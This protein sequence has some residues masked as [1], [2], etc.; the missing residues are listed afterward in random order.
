MTI[1]DSELDLSGHDGHLDESQQEALDEFKKQVEEQF[2][3][4]DSH[5]KWYDDTTLL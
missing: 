5:V 3:G 1:P 4:S 2:G